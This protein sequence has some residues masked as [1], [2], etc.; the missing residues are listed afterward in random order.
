MERR[1]FLTMVGLTVIDPIPSA[2]EAPSECHRDP[3]RQTGHRSLLVRAPSV[4]GLVLRHA[5]AERGQ[6]GLVAVARGQHRLFPAMEDR[7]VA[8]RERSRYIWIR[9]SGDEPCFRPT[10]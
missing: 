1:E 3:P 7:I 6:D 4:D 10:S 8:L 5:P 2:I 9:L